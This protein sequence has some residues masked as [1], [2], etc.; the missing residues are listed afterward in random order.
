MLYLPLNSGVIEV[1]RI[2]KPILYI[3]AVFDLFNHYSSVS[4]C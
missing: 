2:R 4:Q 3:G 1:W